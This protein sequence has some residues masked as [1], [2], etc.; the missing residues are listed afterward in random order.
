MSESAESNGEQTAQELAA[1][2]LAMGRTRKA[3]AAAA[4]CSERQVYR[5]QHTADFVVLVRRYRG[6]VIDRVVGRL[7]K[8]AEKSCGVLE[9][10]L[11]DESSMV[12]IRACQSVLTS[13]VSLHEHLALV[14]R[15]EALEE[16]VHS[17]Q[18]QGWAS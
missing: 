14:A 13:F 6:E 8:L 2:C 7:S 15:V 3:A 10:M 11:T 5:W 9:G 18:E 17:D 12:R 1:R 4:Q 16:R